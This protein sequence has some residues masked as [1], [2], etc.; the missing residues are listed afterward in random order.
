MRQ[1]DLLGS[2]KVVVLLAVF[3][4]LS[5]RA[6]AE[7]FDG[8]WSVLQVCETSP[9]GARGYKWAYPATVTD[10]YFV[11]QYRQEG[12]SPSMSLK[13]MI[14]ADG[15]ATLTARGISGD[16]DHNVKFAPAQ[17]PINFDV[18]AKF[19][20]KTGTGERHTGRVCT[21]TFTKAR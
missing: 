7:T 19:S 4:L 21:F 8:Q 18:R 16:S 11:G 5:F 6:F 2:G 10:G 20:G 14:K 9:E 13:G 17:T 3:C 12:Q 1:V 15:S